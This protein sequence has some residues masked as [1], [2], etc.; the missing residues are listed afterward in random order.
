MP[1]APCVRST[2]K[3]P[4]IPAEDVVGGQ[5]GFGFVVEDFRC[6][7]DERD[8]GSHQTLFFPFGILLGSPTGI[9]KQTSSRVAEITVT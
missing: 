8:L 5:G 2:G 9:Q 1:M 6:G 3:Y 7:V 4:L